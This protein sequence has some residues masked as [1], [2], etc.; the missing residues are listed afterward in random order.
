MKCDACGHEI[1]G[2]YNRVE[3]CKYIKLCNHCANVELVK[4]TDDREEMIK[5]IRISV[6]EARKRRFAKK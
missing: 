6:K 4:E 2:R 5:I 1:I 3:C